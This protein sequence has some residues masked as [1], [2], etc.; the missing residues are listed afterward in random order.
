MEPILGQDLQV[1][2]F[3][4]YIITFCSGRQG[5]S[6][7]DQEYGKGNGFQNRVPGCV[8]PHMLVFEDTEGDGS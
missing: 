8:A 2:Q 3:L 6:K 1:Y 5:S 4:E 7:E